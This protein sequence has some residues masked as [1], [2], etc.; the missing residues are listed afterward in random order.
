[1]GYTGMESMLHSDN[2]SDLLWHIGNATAKTLKAR[3]KE[4]DDSGFNTDCFDDVGMFFRDVI[5]PSAKDSNA[6]ISNEELQKVAAK[7]L[8]GLKKKV[9]KAKKAKKEWDSANLREHLG[10]WEGMIISLMWF[11]EEG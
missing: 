2:A 7:T 4:R 8:K 9:A 5:V 3:L 10:W 1:M 6:F 11:T